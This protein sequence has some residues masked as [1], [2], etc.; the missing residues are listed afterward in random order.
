LEP[1][2]AITPGQVCALY[3]WTKVLGSGIIG[4]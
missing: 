1:Q 2:R 4:Y 3:E